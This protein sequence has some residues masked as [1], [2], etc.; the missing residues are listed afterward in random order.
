L[1]LIEEERQK[2]FVKRRIRD[3]QGKAQNEALTP[4][5]ENELEKT[6]P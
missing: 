3:A 4:R 6:D 2:L 1:R 5:D